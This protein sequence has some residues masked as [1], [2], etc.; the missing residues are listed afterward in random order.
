M[1]RHRVLAILVIAACGGRQPAGTVPALQPSGPR[2]REPDPIAGSARGAPYLTA[3]AAIVQPKWAGFL[4]DCRMRLPRSHALND[5]KLAMTVELAIPADG[6]A[7]VRVVSGSGNGD[8]DTAVFDVLGDAKPLPPPPPELMSDDERVHIRWLFARDR[9][10]AGSATAQ[11]V[12]VPLPLVGVVDRMLGQGQID[13]AAARILAAPTSDPDRLLATEKLMIAVLR[14]A[15]ASRSSDVRIAAIEAVGRA[16]LQGLARVVHAQIASA[17]HPDDV[18]LAAIAT[19]AQLGDPNAVPALRAELDAELTAHPD[20]ALAKVAAL[21]TLGRAGEVTP[22]LHAQLAKPAPATIAALAFAPDP[23]LAPRLGAWATHRDPRI[24]AAVCKALPAAAPAAAP[25]LV[26]TGLRDGDA[27]VRATCVDAA[28][29]GIASGKR[30]EVDPAL[31]RRLRELAKDRDRAVRARAYAALALA[32]TSRAG[33]TDPAPEVRAAAAAGASQAELASLA[34]D[35]DPDVRAAALHAL[36]DRA[37]ELAVR[38]AGDPAPQ[39]RKAAVAALTSESVLDQLARDA[40]PEV[41]TAAAIR[42]AQRRGRAAL[43]G[44]WLGR[45]AQTA[46]GGERVRIALAWLLA[47]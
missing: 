13:R 16:K 22:V 25:R 12:D 32:D 26:T 11:I 35:R 37:G 14:D 18:R 38:A 15:L 19:A 39:V 34:A 5:P 30:S 42:L 8:F 2:L 23:Q 20:I 21:A 7:D 36:G 41:A 28:I 29:R 10:Q 24:R 46:P 31:V 27:T 3:V 44:P 4:E 9:R 47:H 33:I 45:L 6:H 17:D 1:G 40:S 43:V